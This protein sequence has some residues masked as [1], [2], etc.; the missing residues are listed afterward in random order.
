MKEKLAKEMFEQGKTENEI[1]EAIGSSIFDEFRNRGII[2][3]VPIKKE[4]S[5]AID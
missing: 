5:G 1:R 2:P 3:V 4:A